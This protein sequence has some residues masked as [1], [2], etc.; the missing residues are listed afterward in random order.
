MRRFHHRF[1]WL[2]AVPLLASLAA[3][4]AP[5]PSQPLTPAQS[6]HVGLT[7]MNDVVVH[8]ESL[9]LAH[10]YEELPQQ[11]AQ[12]E[13]G[14][15]TLQQGLGLVSPQQRQQLDRL[16]AKA[17]V[18]AIAMSEAAGRHNDPMLKLTHDQLAAA[19]SAAAQIFPRELQP[20]PGGAPPR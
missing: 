3:A 6:V 4:Q 20:A 15:T 16:L 1:L 11:R 9:I 10:S 18:A 8:S 13:Q 12:F 5:P 17:R 14:L 19:V 7:L 2:L